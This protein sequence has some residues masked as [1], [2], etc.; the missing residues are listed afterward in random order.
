M[1]LKLIYTVYTLHSAPRVGINW[2]INFAL[3]V[4][5]P[6]FVKIHTLVYAKMQ[7]MAILGHLKVVVAPVES[8][9]YA[10]FKN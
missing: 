3:R 6:F 7:I 1:N 10:Y 5:K 8:L 9:L 2:L 4:K